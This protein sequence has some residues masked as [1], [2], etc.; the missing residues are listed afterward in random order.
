MNFK[1]IQD[2]NNDISKNI[3]Q[4]KSESFELVVGIPRSGMLPASIIALKLNLPLMTLT[5]FLIN[6]SVSHGR[7][8]K[9]SSSIKSAHSARKILIIDDSINSGDSIREVKERVPS[10]LIKKCKLLAVYGV[11][12]SNDI[13]YILNIVPS[14]RIFEWNAMYHGIIEN[15]CFDIDGVLCAD[16]TEDENDDSRKYHNF[17]ENAKPLYLPLTKIDTLVTNRL[18]KY[19]PQTEAWLKKYNIKYNNLEMLQVGSKAERL[20]QHDYFKHKSDIYKNSKTKIFY[21]SSI[22]QAQEI[23][24]RTQKPVYCV[25][26]H[27][28]ITPSSLKTIL[29][30][31]TLKWVIK[32]RLYKYN[33]VRSVHKL[34]KSLKVY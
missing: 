31:T 5:E 7:T 24:K 23:F 29:N 18:E 14:P 22:Q 27:I 4:L 19:R 3:S 10:E 11:Q 28:L 6:S 8:R 1:S 30:P 17:L 32:E 20:E 21:E 33:V 2:L 26:K 13:D 12:K 15:A 9:P 16:P 34:A 25:D